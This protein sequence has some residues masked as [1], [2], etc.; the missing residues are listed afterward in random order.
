MRRLQIG[1]TLCLVFGEALLERIVLNLRRPG[2]RRC[3]DIRILLFPFLVHDF[4]TIEQFH[5]ALQL[6]ITTRSCSRIRHCNTALTPA[7][8]AL[9]KVN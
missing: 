2:Q 7:W 1:G 5:D 6:L 4:C 3:R 9:Q 8:H